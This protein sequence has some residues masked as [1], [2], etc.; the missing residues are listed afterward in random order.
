[1]LDPIATIFGPT[2]YMASAFTGYESRPA[3]VTLARAI[4]TALANQT[5]LVA[6]APT[7]T[8]KSMA[9]CAPL[10]VYT[11][12]T[13]KR[14]VVATA[15][16]ALLEQL[17]TKDL[18]ALRALLPVPFSYALIKGR[19]NYLCRLKASGDESEELPGIPSPD[20]AKQLRAIDE[21]AKHTA[22]GDKSELPFVPSDSVWRQRSTQREDCKRRGCPR[23]AECFAALAH[24]TASTADIVVTNQHLLCAHLAARSLT[25]LDLILPPFDIVI[26]DE[27]HEA[28][29][30]ARDFFGYSLRASSWSRL[31]TWLQRAASHADPSDRSELINLS[32]T[33]R[34]SSR[35][36]FDCAV[37]HASSP[38]YNTRLRAPGWCTD[39][40]ALDTL[41]AA[42]QSIA[43]H[44]RRTAARYKSSDIPQEARRGAEAGNSFRRARACLDNLESMVTVSPGSKEQNG[45]AHWITVEEYGGTVNKFGER[46]DVRRSATLHGCPVSVAGM[47]HE[48]LWGKADSVVAVSATLATHA[49]P[50]GFAF[51]RG[52]LGFPSDTATLAVPSPFDMRTQT[53]LVTPTGLPLPSDSRF[54]AAVADILRRTIL[55]ARGRTLWL[56]TSYRVLNEVHSILSA[57]H[58]PY[59]ILRQG[60]MPRTSLVAKWKRDTSSVLLG[61]ASLWTGIDAP[62]ETC[63]AVVIDKL[64]FPSPADP[65]NDAIGERL[66][67]EAFARDSLPRAIIALR[68]GVGR[69]IRSKTDRGVV[70]LCDA[71]L[72]TKSYGATVLRALGMPTRTNR[73]EAVGQW[74]D[75]VK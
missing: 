9:Y 13:G 74:L 38:A 2:G 4:A 34:D 75:G 72:A 48:Q 41:T 29:S 71:R 28:A 67:K 51:A 10:A 18:P 19:G 6:D 55:Q 49:G 7:G 35:A 46:R 65:I 20:D 5:H 54:P 27:A 47:L 40:R 12:E 50:S 37:T 66:G 11:H 73:V 36:V 24:A 26:L 58:L 59:R 63:S 52:E 53:L 62:G 32:T 45:W 15:N 33:V 21:W 1:M 56:F 70:V 16:N 61:T 22:T 68:Q 23:N 43:R 60:D 39:A 44:A 8:G 14:A 69:L 42:T 57:A 3:Q 25:G 17:C 64:P 30:I 31:A